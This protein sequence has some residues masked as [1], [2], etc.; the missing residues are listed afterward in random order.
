MFHDYLYEFSH[1]ADLGSFSAA[2]TRLGVSQSTLTRHVCALESDL[3]VELLERRGTGIR[4]TPAGR[5]AAEAG[6]A[7]ARLGAD[8]EQHF[9]NSIL[10]VR[11]RKIVV[12]GLTDARGLASLLG[13]AADHLLLS[14]L[15]VSLQYLELGAVTDA[16][17]ALC[18][19]TCDLVLLYGAPDETEGASTLSRPLG[20]LALAAVVPEAHPL[21]QRAAV[22]LDDLARFSFV[23][24]SGRGTIPAQLWREFAHAALA[25]GFA[26]ECRAVGTG[27]APTVSDFSP[28]DVLVAC[29]QTSQRAQYVGDG[30]VQVPVMDV[31]VPVHAT[32]RSDDGVAR[33][34]LGE[35]TAL[36][37]SDR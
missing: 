24:P 19:G 16:A 32:V 1:V 30:L 15:D 31:R 12:A 28:T 5:S 18:D 14:N 17:A 36:L 11:Q 9:A 26:L 10:R 3:G 34:L 13:K 7:L 35:A 27:I 8:L 29:A 33:R 6:S 20:S 2:A 4:L 21:A 22:R 23:R 25:R 37:D